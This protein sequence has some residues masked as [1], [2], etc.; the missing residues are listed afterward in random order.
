MSAGAVIGRNYASVPHE[1]SIYSDIYRSP[2]MAILI[3]N[4]EV[5]ARAREL[6]ALTGET[7]AIS[8]G[9]APIVEWPV[10]G[11]IGVGT[12]GVGRGMRYDRHVG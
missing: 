12:I 6:A 9:T 3:K 5:E 4:P 2:A 1:A 11:T 10:G 7:P 8:T